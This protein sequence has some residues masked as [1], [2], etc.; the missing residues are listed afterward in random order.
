M[1]I[2]T[3]KVGR[4]VGKPK[5]IGVF[6]QKVIARSRSLSAKVIYS[7]RGPG[8][9]RILELTYTDPMIFKPAL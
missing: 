4:L 5:S 1:W 2:G 3:E 8:G 7:R 9:I 6:F